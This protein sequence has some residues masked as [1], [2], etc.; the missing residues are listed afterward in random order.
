MGKFSRLSKAT[1]G[2]EKEAA[3]DVKKSE[4]AVTDIARGQKPD[5]IIKNS[6]N[7]LERSGDPE[8][9]SGGK[10]N[11]LK[12]FAQKG[13]A[14]H[15]YNKQ[16]ERQIGMGGGG[17]NDLM[18]RQMGGTMADMAAAGA[19]GAGMGKLGMMG[20]I[21]KGVEIVK[22]GTKMVTSL[23]KGDFKGMSNAAMELK[24]D[25]QNNGVN[26]MVDSVGMLHNSNMLNKVQPGTWS[27]MGKIDNGTM[28]SRMGFDPAQAAM[29]PMVAQNAMSQQFMP[30]SGV[31]QDW[32]QPKS[33]MVGK[34]AKTA[35]VGAGLA[36]AGHELS[37]HG[38]DIK[39]ALS[40]FLEPG[41]KSNETNLKE[42]AKVAGDV[43]G[44][45]LDVAGDVAGK[46]ADYTGLSALG[47]AAKDAVTGPVDRGFTHGVENLTKMATGDQSVDFSH[48]KSDEPTN[49]YAPKTS[50][51]DEGPEL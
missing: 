20:T 15:S 31:P 32:G 1:K 41:A 13:M 49:P 28:A 17:V 9:A 26:S 24:S 19:V 14:R 11:K 51:K 40:D 12:D 5:E 39:G 7:V 43:G 38:D 46:V 37:E 47:G 48:E 23:A 34:I 30:G 21:M 3:K 50:A 35:V 6:A 25:F 27:Q 29:N 36:F 16:M 45:A 18:T 22:D 10:F 42:G 44:K 4:P 33:S 8:F 2:A